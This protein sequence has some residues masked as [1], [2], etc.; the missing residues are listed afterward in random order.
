MAVVV[1]GVFIDKKENLVNELIT[2]IDERRTE[3]ILFLV[4]L[5]DYIVYFLRN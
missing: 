2:Q 1:S 3:S 4:C 5:T